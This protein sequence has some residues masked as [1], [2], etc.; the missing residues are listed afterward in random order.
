MKNDFSQGDWSE[1]IEYRGHQIQTSTEHRNWGSYEGQWTGA[2]RIYN[3]TYVIAQAE[4][5][6]MHQ[7]AAHAS[8]NA[9]RMARQ[10]VDDLVK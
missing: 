9:E 5:F 3:R 8:T 1:D 4:V 10:V 2:Y 7:S 6:G